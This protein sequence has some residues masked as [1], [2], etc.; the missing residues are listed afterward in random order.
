MTSTSKPAPES[1]R[2]DLLTG[3]AEIADFLSIHRTLV[4]RMV[5]TGQLPVFR[6]GRVLHARRSALL[7][8]VAK[9]EGQATRERP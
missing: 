8:H 9:L 5:R 1:L 4:Y 7:S 2:D 3:G 6:M